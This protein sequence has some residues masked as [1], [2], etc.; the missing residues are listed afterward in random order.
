M[1]PCAFHSAIHIG[2][3]VCYYIGLCNG[4]S[5]NKHD[6]KEHKIIG[7]N[8]ALHISFIL[9]SYIFMLF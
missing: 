6:V 9:N 1:L 2:H 8:E 7:Y 3:S 5:V 4:M